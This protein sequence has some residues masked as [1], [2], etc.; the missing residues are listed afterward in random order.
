LAFIAAQP[1][2]AAGHVARFLRQDR[3]FIAE[4]I[5]WGTTKNDGSVANEFGISQAIL[6]DGGNLGALQLAF[7]GHDFTN[8]AATRGLCAREGLGSEDR[9]YPPDV[10]MGG[11]AGITFNPLEL[12]FFK[13]NRGVMPAYVDAYARW[14]VATRASAVPAEVLAQPRAHSTARRCAALD[15]LAGESPLDGC[16]EPRDAHR[17]AGR[18]R[19][20]RRCAASR[21][22][23][24]RCCTTS[25]FRWRRGW[26]WRWRLQVLSS[27]LGNLSVGPVT[28]PER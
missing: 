8:E 9:F 23:R 5:V 3:A 7:R 18:R 4:R 19:R 15:A 11:P 21:I 6:R 10:Y 14:Q 27:C 22:R 26:R 16:G 12:V 20:G 24:R 25:R 17:G 2:E 1:A 28:K 13:A